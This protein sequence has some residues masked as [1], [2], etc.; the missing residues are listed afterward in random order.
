MIRKQ[1]ERAID[2]LVAHRNIEEAVELLHSIIAGSEENTTW[3]M[4]A[5]VEAPSD[6][7]VEVTEFSWTEEPEELFPE[8]SIEYATLPLELLDPEDTVSIDIVSIVE[9]IHAPKATEPPVDLSKYSCVVDSR[10]SRAE[11]MEMVRRSSQA[12]LLLNG[13]TEEEAQKITEK[14]AWELC[15]KGFV[16]RCEDGK[17]ND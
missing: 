3:E 16:Q 11:A 13:L 17:A 1:I 15:S 4:R 9:T 8:D 10:T 14:V 6:V 5:I 7:E 2:L 12:Y